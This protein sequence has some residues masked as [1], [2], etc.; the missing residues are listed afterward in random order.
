MEINNYCFVCGEA[1][2]HGLQLEFSQL[3]PQDAD[4]VEAGIQFSRRYQGWKEIVHGGLVSTVLDEALVKAL[5]VHHFHCVTA[6]LNVRFKHPLKTGV[7]YRLTGKMT[8]RK[9]RLVFAESSISDL[10]GRV[11]AVARGKMFDPKKTA[12]DLE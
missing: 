5:A 4:D 12:V 7:K 2:P 1:N 11:M 9:G 10:R 8:G 6:E 3:P